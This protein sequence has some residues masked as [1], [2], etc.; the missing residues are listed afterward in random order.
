MTKL[1]NFV[2]IKWKTTKGEPRECYYYRKPRA[3]KR[4]LVP[5]GADYAQA[6]RHY[7]ELLG[8]DTEAPEPNT[9]AAVYHN[10]IEWAD[11]R[12]VS[13]LSP[14]T[15]AD[16][17]GYWKHL[18]PVFEHC[19]VDTLESGWMF[20]Y[21]EQRS[22]QVAA[23]KELKFL[24][25][26]CNWAKSRGKMHGINPCHGIMQQLEIDE[27]RE[28]Y[29]ED[30]WYQLA[31]KHG[32][33][34]IKDAM[35]FTYLFANRP[36]ETAAAMFQHI[37]GDEL[38]IELQKT[39][40]K[41][42]KEKRIPLD[43]QRLA[44]INRQK[45][46]MPRSFYLVSDNTGQRI[47]INASK[48]KSEWKEARDK[49]EAEAAEKGIPFTRFQLRDL[50]AKAATDIAR[51]YGIEAAR[52]MLG[53]TTQKQTAAYIRSVKGAAKAALKTAGG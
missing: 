53:H 19:S 49:A 17:K 28:I 46:K 29:V 2:T 6:I 35:E 21:F 27:T 22:S 43:G 48:F 20:T 51:D 5:L 31:H 32:S 40:G 9:V 14:R 52:L 18:K 26:M 4:E 11:N 41:G 34:L 7:A 1:S 24:S 38:V 8:I 12:K 42:L 50:R 23:K 33:Q 3:E 36:A 37:Q 47:R 45:A 25:T 13:K 30:A 15:I 39:K 10:Y 16:R 44:Y